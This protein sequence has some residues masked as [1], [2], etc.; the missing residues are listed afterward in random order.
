MTTR[1][2]RR[3]VRDGAGGAGKRLG[4]TDQGRTML[5]ASLSFLHRTDGTSNG[6]GVSSINGGCDAG[7]IREA[8]CRNEY[9]LG[10]SAALR[11]SRG[12]ALP[13]TTPDSGMDSALPGLIS[14][15]TEET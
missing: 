6:S 2:A 15:F 5:S 13:C 11:N 1:P 14:R 8:T 3:D 12:K 10:E 7:L 9:L 4:A